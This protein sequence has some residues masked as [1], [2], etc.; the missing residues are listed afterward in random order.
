MNAPSIL[1]TVAFVLIAIPIFIFYTL[2]LLVAVKIVWRQ[3]RE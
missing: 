3:L 1:E 2:L